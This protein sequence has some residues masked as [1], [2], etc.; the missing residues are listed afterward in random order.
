MD[1]FISAFSQMLSFDTLL[2]MNIGILVGLFFGSI[3]GLNGNLAITVLLPFTFV[4]SPVNALLMLTSIF[5]AAN[6]GGSISAIL[7]NTPGTNAAVATLIDGYPINKKGF[8]KKALN[9]ALFSS[10]VGG[11]VSSLALLFF[12]PQLAKIALGFG[13]VEYFAIAVF[14]LSVIAAVSGKNIYKGIAAGLF[15]FMVSMVG[16]DSVEGTAR[17]TFGNVDFYGGIKM[18]PALLGVFAITNIINRIYKNSAAA[19]ISEVSSDSK[20]DRL[21]LADIKHTF[22]TI[23]KSSSIGTF[24]GAIPG[25]GGGI[26]SFIAYNEA[27]RSAKPNE[28]F[29]KGE[30]KGLAAPE[31]ANNGATAATLIP[32]LTLGIPGDVVAATLL[33]AFMMHGL[34]PGPDLF[35]EQGVTIYAILFGIVVTNIFILAQGKYFLKHVAKLTKIPDALLNAMLLIV[36]ATGAYTFAGSLFDMKVLMVF[37]VLG[38]Y[39]QKFG[40]PM[41]PIVLGIV[42]GPIAEANLRKAMIVHNGDLTVFLT[43]PISL[44]FLVLTVFFVVLLKRSQKIQAKQEIEAI[45]NSKSH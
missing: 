33:G 30:L 16:I 41:V 35:R 37:G 28:H 25:A 36:V 5:F 20:D 1:V 44:F 45:I 7:I 8:P 34:I 6:F 18:L 23:L 31:S 9:L 14:G 38:Y 42:L 11:L 29:G 21:T 13:A 43:Q 15:G 24:I 22:T 4:M 27:K 19:T 2:F 40:F 10:F 12:A 3:P 26:A 32:L 39:M 17:F